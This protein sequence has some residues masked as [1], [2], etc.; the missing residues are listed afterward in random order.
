MTNSKKIALCGVTGA[1]S[2]TI[3]ALGF[4]IPLMTYTAPALAAC[5]ILPIVY[6]FKE[7]SA[8]TL[9]LSVSFLALFLLP[10]KE[11]ALMYALLFGFYTV[12]KLKI[13]RIKPVLLRAAIKLFYPIIATGACYGLLLIVFPSP[14]LISD[15][16]D[17]S[18]AFLTLIFVLFI[19]TF[20]IYDIALT[21]V[22]LIYR[23]KLRSK[24]F[25]R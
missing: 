1:L 4:M 10:D 18:N 8:F 24:I 6:E 5:L 20:I 16:Q 11:L 21:K 2:I 17:A 3:L 13:D 14:S 9:Y 22:F 19:I 25:K 15:F 7:K 12:F 23:Y